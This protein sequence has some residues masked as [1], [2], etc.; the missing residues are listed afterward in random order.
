MTNNA[1]DIQDLTGQAAIDKFKEIVKHEET[2]LFSTNLGTVPITTRPM[3][4]QKVCDQGNFWFMSPGD[5]DKNRE[6]EADPRVQLFISNTKNYEF[7]SVYGHATISRDQAKIDEFFNAMHKAWFPEGK[8][9]PNITIIKVTP[10]EGFYW[11]TKDGKLVS[12]LK[13]AASAVM[14]KTLQEGVEGTISVGR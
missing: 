2:C 9:D 6:I 4:V 1:S 13:I 14:G 8:D 3:G 10:E 5:S 12:I 7:L 11:D